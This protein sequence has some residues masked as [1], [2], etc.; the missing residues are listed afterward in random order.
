VSR[1]RFHFASRATPLTRESASWLCETIAMSRKSLQGIAN[2]LA[3][4]TIGERLLSDLPSLARLPNGTITVDVL[5][6]RAWHETAGEMELSISSNLKT[7][8]SH[9]LRMLGGSLTE[10]VRADVVFTSDS[11]SVPTDRKRLV[12]FALEARA[13]V[14]TKQREFQGSHRNPHLWYSTTWAS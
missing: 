13:V 5:N 3:A 6:G 4:M 14:A 2:D 11:Q 7:W 1:V 10:L 12:H 9:Q 8:L